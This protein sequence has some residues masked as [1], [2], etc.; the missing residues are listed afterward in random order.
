M[1]IDGEQEK[2]YFGSE[3]LVEST[4][5]TDRRRSAL[6]VWSYL[7]SDA[8]ITVLEI[9]QLWNPIDEKILADIIL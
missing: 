6:T 1:T 4:Q 3:S 5:R 8:E 7:E 9:V 2:G